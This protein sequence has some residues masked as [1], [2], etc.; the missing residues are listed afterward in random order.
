MQQ[1][2]LNP[3]GRE[4]KP[5]IRKGKAE[6]VCRPWVGQVSPRPPRGAWRVPRSGLSQVGAAGGNRVRAAGHH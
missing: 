3:M 4:R 2:S 6:A 5:L 1:R